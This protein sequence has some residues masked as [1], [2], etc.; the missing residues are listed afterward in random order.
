MKIILSKIAICKKSIFIKFTWSLKK[1][2]NKYSLMP[3]PAGDPTN[4]RD[5]IET[6]M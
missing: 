6:P 1:R 3:I 4:R 2:I 5:I